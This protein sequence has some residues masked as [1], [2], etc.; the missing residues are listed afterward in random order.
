MVFGDATGRAHDP[1]VGSAH[2]W[3]QLDPIPKKKKH[4]CLW[5]VPGGGA[6]RKGQELLGAL[7]KKA[8]SQAR[9]AQRHG[10]H[11]G[12]LHRC[13]SSPGLPAVSAG[14]GAAP[15]SVLARKGSRSPGQALQRALS[16]GWALRGLSWRSP[17]QLQVPPAPSIAAWTA[18]GPR[19][20]PGQPST[21]A[22]KGCH[23]SNPLPCSCSPSPVA[24]SVPADR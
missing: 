3:A 10:A 5:G 7:R 2:P 23:L 13:P 19:A 9:P 16:V 22:G 17:L 6:R 8:E 18:A 24:P 21:Q 15:G 1:P 12:L 4:K 20:W 14:Q 11:P